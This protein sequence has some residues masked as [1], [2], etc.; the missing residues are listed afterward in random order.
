MP[1]F[2]V[3][4]NDTGR[5]YNVNVT[6]YGS[7][8]VH[9]KSDG[10]GLPLGLL[11][12]ISLIG[13]PIIFFT[14]KI[15]QYESAPV[16]YIVSYLVS[17]VAFIFTFFPSIK[18]KK[19]PNWL[20]K[21]ISMAFPIF[22]YTIFVFSGIIYFTLGDGNC[23]FI[24]IYIVPIMNYGLILYHVREAHLIY[25]MMCALK[26]K[27]YSFIGVYLLQWLAICVVFYFGIMTPFSDIL[28]EFQVFIVCYM[29]I[30]LVD[31]KKYWLRKR[32]Y[33]D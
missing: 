12:I 21:L 14:E 25:P 1:D 23:D 11:W 16:L 29:Y 2:E 28:G 32:M 27:R 26:I 17:L 4:D 18:E 7:V 31:V 30:I 5:T 9:E 6:H 15:Y 3:K 33:L 24:F 10:G 20:K 8:D 22:M 13:M 19:L